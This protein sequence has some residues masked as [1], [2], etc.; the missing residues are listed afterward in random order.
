MQTSPTLFSKERRDPIFMKK[1][2]WAS[3]HTFFTIGLLSYALFLFLFAG[4]RESNTTTYAM[5][6]KHR[7]SPTPTLTLEPTLTPES[8]STPEPT[9]TPKP[10]P[11]PVPTVTPT[12]TQQPKPTPTPQVQAP[13]ISPIFPA[14]TM[15]TVT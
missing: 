11:M 10:T 1:N 13:P 12:A 4:I 6:L 3:K 7:P 5:Y 8:T 14:S 2:I 15:V 9:S